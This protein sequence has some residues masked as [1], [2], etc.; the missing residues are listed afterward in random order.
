MG[1]RSD[2]RGADPFALDVARG[3]VERGRMSS[4]LCCLYLTAFRR[5]GQRE[6]IIEIA[7]CL[8]RRLKPGSELELPRPANERRG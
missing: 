5:A 8:P 1:Q 6:D 2:Q 4:R 3:N 7:A